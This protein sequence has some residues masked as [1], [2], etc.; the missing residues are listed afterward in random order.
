VD[1]IPRK[2]H[3]QHQPDGKYHPQA[4]KKSQ[5]TRVIRFFLKKKIKKM[6]KKIKSIIRRVSLGAIKKLRSSREHVALGAI[7]WY[8]TYSWCT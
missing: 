8:N 5:G 2:C 1:E 6:L 4:A 3:D 7:S